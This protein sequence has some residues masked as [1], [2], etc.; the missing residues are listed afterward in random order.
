MFPEAEEPRE[1]VETE[2]FSVGTRG[3]GSRFSGEKDRVHDEP[4]VRVGL[5]GSV[6]AVVPGKGVRGGFGDI[7]SGAGEA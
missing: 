2:E 4:G 1:F 5:Q 3:S 7:G 6:S